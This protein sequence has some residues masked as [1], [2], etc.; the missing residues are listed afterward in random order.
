ME[1]KLTARQRRQVVAL[2][3]ERQRVIDLAQ[4]E[5]EGI[6]Q[7]IEALAQEWATAAGL[8]VDGPLVFTPTPDGGMVLRAATEAEAGGAA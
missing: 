4:N 1:Y 3:N 7:D 2:S 8:E 6:G 5:L